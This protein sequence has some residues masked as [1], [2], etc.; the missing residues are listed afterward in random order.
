MDYSDKCLE[1]KD[2]K[3]YIVIEQVNYEGNAYLYLVNGSN[4]MDAMF[5]KMEGENMTKID[6]ELFE[7]VIFPMFVEKLKNN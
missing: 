3:R 2:G 7:K 6:P 1:T 4:E 5:V